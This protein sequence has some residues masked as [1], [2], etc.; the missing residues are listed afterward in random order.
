MASLGR[1]VAGVAHELNN[2]ISFVI[3]NV[4][5]LQRYA[6]RLTDY[7]GAVHAET[8]LAER[9]RLRQELRIDRL[10]ADLPELIEGTVEGAER[11][12]D[13]VDSLKRFSALDRDQAQPFNLAQVIERSVHWVAKA[14][15]ER[16]RVDMDMPEGIAVA[17]SSGQM[18]QVLM[19]LVQNALDATAELAAPRLWITARGEGQNVVVTLCDNGPG[20]P[21]DL[22]P[23]IFEPFFTTKPVGKGTG[24]GLAI[25]YG[26]VE[27]H[28][29]ALTAAN[30]PEGGAC[31]TLRLP[32]ARP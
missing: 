20:I 9:Q 29:G 27:R 13:I 5:V 12:R 32:L 17:G 16:F 28:G 15:S 10:L 31:F 19:N 23:H 18:Q 25:S 6:R 2:P 1:L 21:P 26:I 7:L 30:R 8:P 24:L 11:T 14:A 4:Y 22:L 3:G